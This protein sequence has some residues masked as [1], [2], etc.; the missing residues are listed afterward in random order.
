MFPESAVT[1]QLHFV[2]SFFKT[3]YEMRV[4]HS[5]CL[6]FCNKQLRTEQFS[7][8]ETDRSVLARITASAIW[9]VFLLFAQDATQCCVLLCSISVFVQAQKR[10]AWMCT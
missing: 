2:I 10:G 8:Q 1:V 7:L 9:R 6:S 4:L 5:K 3:D